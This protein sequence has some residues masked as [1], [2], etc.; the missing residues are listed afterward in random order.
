MKKKAGGPEEYRE[1]SVHDRGLRG[2]RRP[3]ILTFW[4]DAGRERL[5]QARQARSTPMCA[6][7]SLKVWQKAAAG[8]LSCWE[9]HR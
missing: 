5:V 8:E 6:A 9:N 3:E 2:L 7:A 4:R 1:L